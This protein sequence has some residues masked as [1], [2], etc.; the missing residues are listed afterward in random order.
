MSALHT[1]QINECVA[2][3]L[4]GSSINW[5]GCLARDQLPPNFDKI[6]RPFALIFNTHPLS[7]PGEHWLAMYSSKVGLIEFFDSYGYPP[8]YYLLSDTNSQY[9]YSDRSIQSFGSNV[10]GHYCIMFI[11]LR[12]QNRSFKFTTNYLEHKLSDSSV[13]RLTHD[14]IHSSISDMNCTGQAC[15][16][17]HH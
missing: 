17:K 4:N 5:L 11:Y 12:S 15:I 14:L 9:I 6:R 8:S 3:I 1:G 2:R 16:I 13:V 10:C 7:K